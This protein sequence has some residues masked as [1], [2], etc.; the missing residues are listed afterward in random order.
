MHH[1]VPDSPEFKKLMRRIRQMVP[2]SSVG[3]HALTAGLLELLFHFTFK[4]GTNGEIGMHG[5]RSLAE[6]V[7]WRECPGKLIEL[8]FDTGW[9][10][11]G[12][13]DSIKL[14]DWQFH[15]RE[16]YPTATR[17]PDLSTAAWRDMRRRV[18]EEDGT[19]CHYCGCD[20]S[21]APTVDHVVPFKL[22][23]GMDRENLVVACKPCNGRKG[24][25]LA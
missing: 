4:H 9:L 23:G 19:I 8:L 18:I 11:R 21:H 24:D 3:P 20:C 25:R 2:R 6:Y 15:L 17:R 5:A 12:A 7:G 1:K 22:G 10:V 16:Y 13:A 14:R